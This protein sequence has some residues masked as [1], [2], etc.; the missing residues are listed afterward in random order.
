MSSFVVG[1][2]MKKSSLYVYEYDDLFKVIK[3]M[4][5]FNVDTISV[6]NE[7]FSLRG[8]LTKKH[9]KDYLQLNSYIFG[10]ILNS[11]KNIKVKNIMKENTLPLTFYA[12]TKAEDAFCLMK[13][14]NNK[15]APVVE[16]P[17]EKK[18]IGFLW[19]QDRHN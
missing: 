17:W 14:L 5:K 4:K 8:H 18:V 7:N 16:A 12:E 15:Y 9:I 11:L 19:L 10:N 3:Y 13:H 1:D 2:L 6:I